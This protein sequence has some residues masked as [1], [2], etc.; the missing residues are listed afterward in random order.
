VRLQVEPGR[1]LYG[2]TAIHLAKVKVVKR[3]TRPYPYAWVLTD[4]T[5]FFLAGGTMD[6]NRYPYVVANR[7]DEPRTLSADIVGHSCFA[8]I[9]N[10]GARVPSS[11]RAT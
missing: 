7:A 8:D 2:D 11:S 6:H 4:T 5:Y 1:W 3:Q 10:L 9:I